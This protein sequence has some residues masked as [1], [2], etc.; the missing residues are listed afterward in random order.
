MTLL[1]FP[2]LPT[3]IPTTLYDPDLCKVRTITSF[4]TLTQNNTTWPKIVSDAARFNGALMN[5]IQQKGYTVQ[6]IRL[7]TNPFGEYIDT[8]S[9]QSALDDMKI[10]SDTLNSPDM[11]DVRIRFAIGEARNAQE[12]TLVPSII[13]H[14][15]DLGNICIN[16]PADDLGIPD[17]Q[18]TRDAAET[19]VQI[20]KQTKGGE[21]NFNFTVN[22]NCQPLIPYFPASYHRS[23]PEK[24]FVLGLETPDLLSNALDEVDDN[25]DR[26]TFLQSAYRV[27][28]DAL[29]Y[30]VDE[31]LP[32]AHEVSKEFAIPFAGI[33]SSAAP[34]KDCTSIVDLYKKLDIPF[35]GTAGS[36]EVSSLLTKVFKSVEGVNVVGFS[37]LMLAATEDA[38]LAQDAIDR[39]YDIRT[40]LMNSAVC[41]I[42][43]DTVPIPG[44]TSVDKIAAIMRDTGTLAFRLN[45][46]LTVRL[47]P[48][49][50]LQEGDVTSFESDDLCDCGV[51]G[52]P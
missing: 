26:N 32:I 43:L 24:C 30:H 1:L 22:Y 51:L 52:V 39:K 6:T 49:P 23:D 21:G 9:I 4:I 14:F 47:F 35:F 29:Q 45:K 17:A 13:E 42:G 12:L 7:V 20:G 37:G 31:I 33:D 34:S 36:L 25:T 50:G 15:G 5:R 46:P 40:F 44:D 27:M 16:I 41:G 38:G 2:P 10:L 28:G 3:T 18:L 19:V 48:V 8:S 11:P